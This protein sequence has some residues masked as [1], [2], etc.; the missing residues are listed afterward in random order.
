M[1]NRTNPPGRIHI[2]ND[3]IWFDPAEFENFNAS[4]IKL[5]F[6]EICQRPILKQQAHFFRYPNDL[7]DHPLFVPKE[8]R[9][10]FTLKQTKMT[11]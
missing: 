1:E 2:F 5:V 9:T 8:K 4:L 11:T 3:R 7:E 6:W 10:K